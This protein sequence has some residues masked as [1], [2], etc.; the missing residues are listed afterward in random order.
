MADGNN[1][2][3][4]APQRPKLNLK[5]RDPNAAARIEAERQQSIDGKVRNTDD[6][7]SPPLT[8]RSMPSL[9]RIDH[10]RNPIPPDYIQSP[11]GAAKPREVIIATRE[12]K[13]EE[14]ILKE[15]VKKE[16]L[17][18][19]LNAQQLEEKREQEAAVKEIEDQI[20]AEEDAAKKE[21]LLVELSARETKLNSLMERFAK[22]TLEAAMSGEAPRV[23]QLRR[24][25]M[26]GAVA[27][28]V[29]V[30]GALGT[31][32]HPPLPTQQPQQQGFPGYYPAG[33]Q[34][35]Q[36]S[37]QYNPR[38]N[39]TQQYAGPNQ[40]RGGGASG[41][42][43]RGGFDHYNAGG[44]SY[45]PRGGGSGGGSRGGRGGGGRGGVPDWAKEEY[46]GGPPGGGGGVGVA[47]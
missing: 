7:K 15:E 9:S 12:G 42:Q 25:Q 2:E 39:P 20:A 22:I 23:S 26:E 31:M 40:P 3:T 19:R 47:L 28:G 27:V 35:Q 21:V 45:V 32:P 13:S 34:Q 24:Q 41:Y 6:A 14:D 30:G 11:F 44:R 33:G 36:Q 46:A 18:L 8:Q 17:H 4:P 43:Q 5:P 1:G 29:G 10:H 16:K 37:Q 38:Y